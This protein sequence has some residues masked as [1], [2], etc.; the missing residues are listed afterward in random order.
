MNRLSITFDVLIFFAV[1]TNILTFYALFS[2]R[3]WCFD[4]LRFVSSNFIAV[5][6]GKLQSK[7]DLILFDYIKTKT[8]NINKTNEGDIFEN[9]KIISNCR[10]NV[11]FLD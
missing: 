8:C 11:S 6:N 9:L 4:F 3:T 10:T 1:Y 5:K 7:I 2:I